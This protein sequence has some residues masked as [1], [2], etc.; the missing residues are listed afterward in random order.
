MGTGVAPDFAAEWQAQHPEATLL[1]CDLRALH[2]S[3]LP[4]F[5]V[6]IGGIP[7]TCHSILGRAKKRLAG[8]P[9]LSDTGDLFLLV[10]TLLSEC[11]PL[12]C[13]R[14]CLLSAAALPVSCWGRICGASAI[15]RAT[16]GRWCRCPSACGCC[17]R[18][19]LKATCPNGVKRS[20]G[21]RLGQVESQ[22]RKASSD[23][24]VKLSPRSPARP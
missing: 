24:E 9:E 17:G 23:P 2:P 3:E 7:C 6:L 22:N 5:D 8:K 4:A 21:K 15:A 18:P 10:V 1:Q 20:S 19:R 14:M 16:R 11:P 13:L 12:R